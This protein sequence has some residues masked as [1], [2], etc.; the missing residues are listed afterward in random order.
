MTA[1]STATVEV[2][3]R[4][5]VV[6]GG[7]LSWGQLAIWKA[8]VA[9]AP[10]DHLVNIPRVLVVPESR[11][12]DV[13]AVVA[14]IAELVTRH[15]SLRTVVV[16]HGE[17]VRQEVRA[18]GRLPL[19]VRRSTPGNV[20]DDAAAL[21]RE[22]AATSFDH[23]SELPLRG[24]LVVV[25]GRVRRVCLVFDHCATDAQGA[26]VVL[27]ELRHLLTRGVLATPPGDQP[28]DLVRQQSTVDAGRSARAVAH[29]LAGFARVPPVQLAAGEPADPPF[30]RVHLASGA[31]ERALDVLAGRLGV[32]GSTIALAA[33]ARLFARCA[34]RPVVALNVFVGNR[35][36]D[37]HRTAV[38][39]MNQLGLFVV[40][41]GA[42]PFAD[43]VRA[44]WRAALSAYQHAYYDQ[45]A[46]DRELA[47][48]E[49]DTG[50]ETAPLYG[51]ND[52]RPARPARRG[53]A[54]P[55]VGA[56][57]GVLYRCPPPGSVNWRFILELRDVERGVEFMLRVDTR[58]LSAA[59]AER[60]L[61]DLEAL[62]VREAARVSP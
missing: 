49:R 15:E 56:P 40:E 16:A 3:V 37:G 32:T 39:P 46:L 25:D 59:A 6:R 43:T 50:I 5:P 58:Y 61:V 8:I 48:F 29:W 47:A 52:M 36:G 14:A 30:A 18:D 35:V 27:R 9:L 51:F 22:L 38:C 62:L 21:V 55:P 1:P 31:A 2:P 24:G 23:A 44:S 45:A 17:T 60:F 4:G 19:T 42:G 26:E 53:K 10:H 33:A 12:C 34:G 20:A 54:P 28:L 7:P 57:D 41:P 11:Q 13:S